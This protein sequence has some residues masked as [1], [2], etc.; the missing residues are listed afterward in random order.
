MRIALCISGQ[1]R[2]FKEGY[3]SL[4]ENF[5]NR[6]DCD[7]FIH[8]WHSND[9]VGQSYDTTHNGSANKVGIIE[10]NIPEYI[11]NLYKPTKY[12]FEEPKIFPSVLSYTSENLKDGVNPNG[13]YS[14]FYSIFKANEIK[15][16]YEIE[17]AK[18]YDIVI[19]LRFDLQY[20]SLLQLENFDNSKLYVLRSGNP[21][22]YYDIFGF[23]SSSL[24]N[25][26]AN[27]YYDIEKVWDPNKHFIGENILTDGLILKGIQATKID[28]TVNLIRS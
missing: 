3:A 8:S 19:R 23:G 28:Y 18:E 9:L 5:L 14:M 15:K 1:P 16:Q 12:L 2:F 7:I 24:M 25:E 17:I 26:Y 4:K 22:V 13:V 27:V 10:K 20:N 21:L 11:L 6:Y